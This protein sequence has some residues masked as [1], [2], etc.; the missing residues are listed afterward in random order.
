MKIKKVFEISNKT[1]PK[2]WEKFFTTEEEYY[3]VWANNDLSSFPDEIGIGDLETCVRLYEYN[4]KF[5]Y[6]NIFITKNIK[7]SEIVPQSEIDLMIA[8]KKYNI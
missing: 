5:N 8:A 2:K 1:N 6:T 3:T 7:T 4:K